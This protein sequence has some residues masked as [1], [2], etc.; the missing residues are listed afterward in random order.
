MFTIKNVPGFYNSCFWYLEEF[1]KIQLLRKRLRCKIFL[2]AA[3]ILC[4][5]CISNNLFLVGYLLLKLLLHRESSGYQP[6]G[7][8]VHSFFLLSVTWKQP[9]NQRSRRRVRSNLTA[10]AVFQI[11]LR[12][13]VTYFKFNHA[14]SAF[15]LNHIK[16]AIN[17][18][19]EKAELVFFLTMLHGFHINR[20]SFF[21]AL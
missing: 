6:E 9:W 10:S 12:G 14:V 19:G 11:P 15:Y 3:Y 13:A 21:G 16:I 20:W 8:Q 4:S 7:L 2:F 1:K 18:K 17:L 5:T